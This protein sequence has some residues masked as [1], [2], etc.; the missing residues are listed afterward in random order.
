[1]CRGNKMCFSQW[2]WGYRSGWRWV[3]SLSRARDREEDQLDAVSAEEELSTTQIPLFQPQSWRLLL[4]FQ[5][6]A[7]HRC[8][9]VAGQGWTDIGQIDPWVW[10][11]PSYLWS[12]SPPVDSI[13]MY[14]LNPHLVTHIIYGWMQSTILC[15][16]KGPYSKSHNNYYLWIWSC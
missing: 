8:L 3:S 2:W 6:Y 16:A 1:M 4:D 11:W 10:I 9:G 5:R 7:K 13:E 15:A 12:N 14:V